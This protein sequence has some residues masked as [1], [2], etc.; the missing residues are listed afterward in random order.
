MRNASL[1]KTILTM[2][3]KLRFR[4]IALAVALLALFAVAANGQ[5]NRTFNNLG[6]TDEQ[7]MAVADSIHKVII[8][9]DT[10]I[11]TPSCLVYPDNGWTVTKGQVSF[12]LM[13]KGGLDG[14]FF[15]IYLD[16]GDWHRQSA[17]DSAF[18]YCRNTLLAWRDYVYSGGYTK[19]AGFATTP[20]ECRALKKEGK[21][22]IVSCIE[23]GYPVRTLEDLD[24]FY[25]LGVRYI[26]LSHNS[27]NQICDGSRNPETA[28]WH[29]VSPFGY[30]VIERMQQLGIMVDVSHISSEALS[31]VL[32][33]TKAPVIASHSSCRVFRPNQLRNLTDDEIKAIAAVGGVVQVA[34]G[35]FFLTD[36]LPK[37]KVDVKLLADHI[38]H[39]VEVAGVDYV[40]LGTDFDGGGGVVGMNNAGEM[41]NLTVELLKRGWGVEDLRKF[42]GGNL[43]RV[44]QECIDRAGRL[45]KKE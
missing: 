21:R 9:F 2:R 33:V 3:N 10:H 20:D 32:R 1:R 28:V 12:D 15:A 23:N 17:L 7:Y 8:S 5:E 29:G 35:R 14:A 31:D 40:G 25:Q 6:L 45:S 16:Q 41:K 19:V 24:E 38:E 11:D 37:E 27:A 18:N 26:T 39:V 44:W 4:V 22:I 36:K 43:L 13:E 30:K 34:T 42:W